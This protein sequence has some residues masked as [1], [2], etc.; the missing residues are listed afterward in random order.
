MYEVQVPDGVYP[1][2]AFQAQ[3]GGQLMVRAIYLNTHPEAQASLSARE[4]SLRPAAT[5]ALAPAADRP[6]AFFPRW[7]SS[8]PALM[9]SGQAS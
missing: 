2:S 4:R 3:V 8:L 9:A 6:V 5:H 7:R 1:G